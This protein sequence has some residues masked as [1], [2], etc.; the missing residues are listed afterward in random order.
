MTSS[1]GD[2][3]QLGNPK[4]S[5]PVLK[6]EIDPARRFFCQICG[7]DGHHA[8]D[9][10]KSMWCE[11]CRKETRVTTRCVLPKQSKPYMPIFAWQ[12]MV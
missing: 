9:C 3:G 4:T 7:G 10:F 12:W 11:I 8:R 6:K 5:P 2:G 1:S